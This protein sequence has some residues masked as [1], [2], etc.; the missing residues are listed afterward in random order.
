MIK[1][2]LYGS[3]EGTSLKPI[4]EKFIG[5]EE[6]L[7]LQGNFTQV[8]NFEWSEFLSKWCRSK[9]WLV[10][11]KKIRCIW[12]EDG[13]CYELKRGRAKPY[14]GTPDLEYVQRIYKEL[15]QTIDN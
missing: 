15:T 6:F 5:K 14:P 13:S 1:A 3:C 11:G 4:T 10:G 7:N 9:V 12:F 2:M 8:F